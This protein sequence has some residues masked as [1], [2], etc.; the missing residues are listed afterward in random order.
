MSA[1]PLSPS[2]S[3]AT[4]AYVIGE[5]LIS[6]LGLSGSM[7]VLFY[8]T[9]E[10]VKLAASG[11]LSAIAVFWFQRRAS[12]QSNNNLAMLADGKLSQLLQSQAQQQQ[13][14]D[15]VVSLMGQ[16]AAQHAA[17]TQPSAPIVAEAPAP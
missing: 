3:F 9:D 17:S 15:A 10:G 7:L 13:R 6:V 2:E 16:L 5:I 1:P 11:L 4:R 14:T 8:S 12:E